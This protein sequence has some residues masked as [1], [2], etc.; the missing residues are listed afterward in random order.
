[1]PAITTTPI[2]DGH[3][4]IW[5]LA[6]LPWLN[7]P[8]QPRIFGEHEAMRRDYAIAE[9]LDDIAGHGIAQSVYVQTNWAPDRAADEARWVQSVADI[10]GY[11]QA[12]VAY[13]DLADAGLGALLDAHGACGNFRGVRQQLHWHEIPQYRFAPRPDVMNDAAWRK[14]LAEIAARGLVFE[15][16]VFTSQMADGARLARDFP[17]VPF[18]LLHAGML[19]DTSPAGKAAWAEGMKQLAA[20]PNVHVKLSGLGTFVHACAA[21]QLAPIVRET[22]ALFG[23]ERCLFGSN[24]P[25]EKMWTGYADLLAAY[26]EATAELGEAARRAIFHDTAKRL[27][28]LADA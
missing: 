11:P 8:L 27:Y 14:G 12:I 5:R 26:D 13:A 7:G 21:A 28:R 16:Q 4:H 2:I 3:H 9:F 18:V 19:E 6:D 20:Q 10:H 17:D 22:V 25:I 15:L 1:M 24:F 23:A